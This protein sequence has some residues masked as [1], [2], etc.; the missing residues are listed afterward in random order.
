MYNEAHCNA[1][2]TDLLLFERIIDILDDTTLKIKRLNLFDASGIELFYEL[3]SCYL[4]RLLRNKQN[5]KS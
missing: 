1:T 2:V 3:I 4:I 5:I